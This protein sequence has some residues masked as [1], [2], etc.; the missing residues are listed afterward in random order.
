MTKL[1][2]LVKEIDNFSLRKKIVCYLI[3]AL[4]TGIFVFITDNYQIM[5]SEYKGKVSVLDKLVIDKNKQDNK[6]DEINEKKDS[7][8]K[9]EKSS[10]KKSKEKKEEI[11]DEKAELNYVL[12]LNRQYIK[13]I[14]FEYSSDSD[15]IISLH[16]IEENK[17]AK[18]VTKDYEEQSSSVISYNGI[19]LNN[20]IVESNIIINDS[21]VNI[22]DIYI[23]N[24]YGFNILKYTLIMS[25]V[26]LIFI[27]FYNRHKMNSIIHILFLIVVLSVGL[28]LVFNEQFTTG[29]SWD[30]QIHYSRTLASLN[31]GETTITAAEEAN[32]YITY[33][34]YN[35]NT[36]VERKE[37]KK[38]INE[39]LD[40][41]NVEVTYNQEQFHYSNFCYIPGSI[42]IKIMKFLNFNYST[43][44][45]GWRMTSL[46]IYSVLVF[47]AIKRA[48]KYKIL[49]FTVGI[50]PTSIFLAS[51]YSYD[52]YVTSFIILGIS[53]FI[54]I[55]SDTKINKKE[56]FIFI[57]SILFG[58]LSKLIYIP[59]VFL[60][61]IVPSDKFN[62]K[63]QCLMFKILCLIF[64]LILC[65]S[66]L[67]PTM[68]SSD[69][70]SGDPRGGNTCVSCQVEL[71]KKYPVSFIK[72]FYN[73]IIPNF[74]FRFFHISTI[75]SFAYY[76]GTAEYSNY[77]F[78]FLM[79]LVLTI[80]ACSKKSLNLKIIDRFI[81]FII[82]GLII[83]FIYGALFL[84][85]TEV[86]SESI[87]GVQNR[88][89][90][91]LIPLLFILLIPNKL[92]INITENRLIILSS[93]FLI[94]SIYFMIYDILIRHFIY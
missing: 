21:K 87:A 35:Y 89:F 79:G 23:D 31:N 34:F 49:L 39:V 60:L 30:D 15:F 16:N 42:V 83:C 10:E 55:M 72:V 47:I 73:N 33:K 18:E 3:I 94:F 24:S 67:L 43:R 70:I 1:K 13:N 54:N 26:L 77:Y 65:S 8:I 82:I 22:K 9:D 14:I 92:K 74:S 84:S 36:E 19:P 80:V 20:K 76:G 28:L 44:M 51:N 69:I 52:S 5:K 48:K 25:I 86:G 41:K 75:V 66:F 57:L 12:N 71:I 78:L 59:I 40:K 38:Y 37:I 56:V 32:S 81:I 6:K 27:I 88:Y 61:L 17:W 50:I 2:K 29:V 11:K 46:I 91:P 4:L 64:V 63:K 7:S 93:L 90:I 53:S 68:S 62:S 45:M 85:F 58:S